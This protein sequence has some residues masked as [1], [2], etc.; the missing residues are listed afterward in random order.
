MAADLS[1]KKIIMIHGL[2]SKPSADITHELWRRSLCENIRVDNRRLARKLDAHPE[3]FTSAYWA[4]VV[5]HHI[6]DDTAYARKLSI[7]VDKVI[8]ERRAIKD[9]FHVGMGER[10]GGFFKDRGLDLVKLLAGALTVKD[11]V[12]TN[13]LRE[14][15]LYE[16][17][18]YISDQI[19][20]PLENALRRAWDEGREPVILSHSM[21]SFVAYD[22]LW[23]FAH[24]KTD[25]FRQ[26]NRKRL[27]M[28]VTLGSPLGESAIRDL[29]FATHHAMHSAR[30][31]PTN[32]DFW[33]NYACLGDVVSHQKNFAEIFYQP[34]R[35]LG[36]FPARKKHRS[37]DY[38]DL[39]NPFV[40]VT[41][42]GNRHRNKRNPHK[43]YGYLVQP[44]LG[45]WIAD[46]LLDR[47]D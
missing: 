26:Y 44:R 15:E 13:F 33:H 2:A 3:V 31:Y 9:R 12:M 29:L 32:I 8:E 38:V 17:D 10:L 5:P 34:M 36:L 11:N 22:V 27:R 30:Q 43:S 42:A 1:N 19:R 46:Y 45:T 47:L 21:G 25:G 16:Q 4:N 6:P 7:Q 23:R 18:Q 37:I 41:H 14:T 24:R 39:H 35:A 20:A 40:V 28:F